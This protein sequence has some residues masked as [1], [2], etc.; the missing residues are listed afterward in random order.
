MEIKSLPQ[1]NLPERIGKTILSKRFLNTFCQSEHF[2]EMSRFCGGI[3][4]YTLIHPIASEI[5]KINIKT[6]QMGAIHFNMTV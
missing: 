6:R 1:K 4:H 5:A 3:L 2:K